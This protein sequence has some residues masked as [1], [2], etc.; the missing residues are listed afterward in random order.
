MLTQ[1]EIALMYSGGLD[2]TYAAIKLA[3]KYS[4]V[5][6]LTFCNGFC[7]RTA[8]SRKHVALLRNKFGPDKFE[9]SILSVSPIF[10]LFKKNLLKDI[11]VVRSPLLFDLYCRLSMET[12][13]AFYC[14]E[15]KISFLTDGNNPGTQG[16]IFLQQEQY[17]KVARDFFSRFGI[18]YIHPFERLKSRDEIIKYLKKEQIKTGMGLFKRIGITTQLFTQPFCLWAPVAFIFTSNLR[19]FPGIRRFVLSAEKAV[20]IRVEKEKLAEELID[21]LKLSQHVQDIFPCRKNKM[22]GYL[23]ALRR[24]C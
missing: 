1:K 17:L 4:K 19:K 15:R 5:H 2:T 24:S 12:A 16:E 22:T 13:A 10:S 18:Q 8:A 23:R 11:V 21:Y 3:E 9:H 6:L 20:A 7:V 14:M